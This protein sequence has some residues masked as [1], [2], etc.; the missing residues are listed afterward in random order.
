MKYF[1]YRLLILFCLQLLL[2][3]SVKTTPNS[4]NKIQ[5]TPNSVNKIQSIPILIDVRLLND[6]PGSLLKIPLEVDYI[7]GVVHIN[8]QSV[9][10]GAVTRL[11]MQVTAE[12][13]KAGHKYQSNVQIQVRIL[14]T[15][16]LPISNQ[17]KRTTA[18]EEEVVEVDS[19]SVQQL[20]VVQVVIYSDRAGKL[21]RSIS[22]K[23][24]LEKSKI[25][26]IPKRHDKHIYV[27]P[28]M[29]EIESFPKSHSG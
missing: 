24:P 17:T 26:S 3:S 10:N 2:F 4:V 14:V 11:H 7:S 21:V 1:I 27:R 22:T 29:K 19:Y 12:S 18:V 13:D 28:K 6:G 5:S 20:E 23:L 16:S 15:Q 25:H 9:T 8:G